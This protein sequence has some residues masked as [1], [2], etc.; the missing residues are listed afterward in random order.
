MLRT[1]ASYDYHCSLLSGLTAT[2]D[3]VTYG[4]NYPSP[5]NDLDYFHVANMQLPQDVMHVLF[6]GVIPFEIKLMI[7]SFFQKKLFT[8]ETLNERCRYFMYG[9]SELKN[10]PPKDFHARH[11]SLDSK[12]LPLSGIHTFLIL[13]HL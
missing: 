12:K 9:R 2:D 1:T 4:I 13:K 10:R 6:E 11:F 5:L 8:L 7:S 3:S